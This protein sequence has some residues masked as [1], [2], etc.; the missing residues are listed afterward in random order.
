[1]NWSWYKK[2]DPLNPCEM[3][4]TFG[5]VPG[6]NDKQNISTICVQPK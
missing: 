1:M 5:G 3:L 6:V 4:D 2:E